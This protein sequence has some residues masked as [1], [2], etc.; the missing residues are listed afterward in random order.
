MAKKPE[1]KFRWIV[2]RTV[3]SSIIEYRFKFPVLNP[4]MQFSP[5]LTILAL[6]A[7]AFAQYD[8]PCGSAKTCEADCP[9]KDFLAMIDQCDLVDGKPDCYVNFYCA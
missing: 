5:I 4:K 6:A 8:A 1:Y 9:N 2:T 3:H 7:V